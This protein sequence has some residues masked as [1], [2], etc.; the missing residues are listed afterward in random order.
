MKF[1]DDFDDLFDLLKDM[2]PNNTYSYS[3]SKH[4]DYKESER[5]IGDDNIFYTLVL[6]DVDNKEDIKVYNDEYNILITINDELQ[7]SKED[8]I[9]LVSPNKLIEDKQKWTYVNGILDITTYKDKEE[10]ND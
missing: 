8:T 9:N 4:I 10:S 3:D 6:K 5:I 7:P 2:F 1:G